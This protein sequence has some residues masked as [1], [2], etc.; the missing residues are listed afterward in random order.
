MSND[1]LRLCKCTLT[2]FRL[3]MLTFHVTVNLPS[4][5]TTAICCGNV[6]LPRTFA[7]TANTSPGFKAEPQRVN[8]DGDTWQMLSVN[9]CVPT[10]TVTPVV[11]PIVAGGVKERVGVALLV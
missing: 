10:V 3:Q 6:P 4:L 5:P 9:C 1:V 8:E 11:T 2:R 7:V